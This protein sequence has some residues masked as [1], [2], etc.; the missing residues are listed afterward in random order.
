LNGGFSYAYAPSI[1]VKDGTYHL[2]F[3]S[4][5]VLAPT[6][7]AIRY[8]TST[9][10]RTWSAPQIMVLPSFANGADMA[11]CDPSLVFYQGFYYLFYSSAVTTAP[12]VF[13]TVIRVARSVN[14]DGPYLTYTDR[15]TWEVTPP[16]PH[17]IIYPMQMHSLSPPGYG[18]GQQ[19]VIVRDGKLMMWY[20]D[21]SVFVDGQPNL[22]T[23][24]LES[25]D[26]VT[27]TPGLDHATNLIEQASLDV[28][29]D[30]SRAEFEMVRVENE[31]TSS[32]F[33]GRSVSKD[34]ITWKP[35]QNVFPS[36]K[37]PP[38]THDVGMA[39][40]ETGNIATPNTLV[41]FGAPY[42]LA[43]V[44]T[45]GQWDLYGVFVDPP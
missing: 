28:K 14:I 40:D 36:S 35:L 25:T 44:N 21:D 1:V 12:E 38:Y 18:A 37:F 29:Y 16:D 3:C 31:F 41:G 17:V 5:A 9:D 7:D 2:F 8:T 22:Q 23:F 11:A 45:W 32:A 19:S 30:P 4:M 15:G 20:T 39:G 6:W 10:G 33:L 34:G 26:P 24:M 43:N 42:K 27:W 13:Q